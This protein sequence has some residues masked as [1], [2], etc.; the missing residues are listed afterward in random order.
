MNK[1]FPNRLC[2]RS[3]LGRAAADGLAAWSPPLFQTYRKSGFQAK[4]A[5]SANTDTDQIAR[6]H[7]KT[8]KFRPPSRPSPRCAALPRRKWRPKPASFKARTRRRT[9]AR[10]SRRA[11]PCMKNAPPGTRCKT[12]WDRQGRPQG[13]KQLQRIRRD[14]VGAIESEGGYRPSA[15]KP[16]STPNAS[17]TSARP[18]PPP[19]CPHRRRARCCSR[20]TPGSPGSTRRTR[21]YSWT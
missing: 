2:I 7:L 14:L 19:R 9:A 15:N 13:V 3:C 6:R 8:F 5:Q 12:P 20:L 21:F 18:R 16:R 11:S 4:K 10:W 17:T 1:G